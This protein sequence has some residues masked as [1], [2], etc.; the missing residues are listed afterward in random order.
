R[1]PAERRLQS[2]IDGGRIGLLGG[3]RHPRQVSQESGEAGGCLTPA[4]RSLWLPSYSSCSPLRRRSLANRTCRNSRKSST[5][6]TWRRPPT[7]SVATRFP[8]ASLSRAAERSRHRSATSSRPISRRI[9]RQALVHGVTQL[10]TPLSE[11]ASG[12]TEDS[13]IRRC[14]TPPMPSS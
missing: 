14:H 1:L 11:R 10:S 6:A 9:S 5:A 3:G 7:V 4:S 8:E 2:N 13:S 12:G